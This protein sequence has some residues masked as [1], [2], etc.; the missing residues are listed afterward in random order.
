MVSKGGWGRSV[1]A[2]HGAAELN[3]STTERAGSRGLELEVEYSEA[4]RRSRAEGRELGGTCMTCHA[5]HTQWNRRRDRNTWLQDS[6]PGSVL[7]HHLIQPS[8]N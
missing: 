4:W 5:P 1:H 6:R 2:G 7:G 8:L 3:S